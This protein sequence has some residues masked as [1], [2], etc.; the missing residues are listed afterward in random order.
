MSTVRKILTKLPL[1]TKV[2]LPLQRRKP[3]RVEIQYSYRLYGGKVFIVI[4][5]I[6]DAKES[7]RPKISQIEMKQQVNFTNDHLSEPPSNS[8]KPSI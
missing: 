7:L 8:T 2:R 6:I 3:I 4:V 1:I 5:P